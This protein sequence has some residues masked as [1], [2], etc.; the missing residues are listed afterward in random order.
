MHVLVISRS[1]MG[2]QKM[3]R[4]SSSIQIVCVGEKSGRVRPTFFRM[5]KR[6]RSPSPQDVEHPLHTE[7]IKAIS[8]PAK[9]G[10][11]WTTEKKQNAPG[12]SDGPS[13]GDELLE[14]LSSLH[15]F[16]SDATG[17]LMPD[18]LMEMID[19]LAKGSLK[20]V[21][22]SRIQWA[23]NQTRD[24]LR[25]LGFDE[26]FARTRCAQIVTE[27]ARPMQWPWRSK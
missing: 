12:L 22:E 23:Q 2:A 25:P 5:Q 10:S 6:S 4:V 3:A 18:A 15:R 9:D 14:V 16:G 26:K 24:V 8:L 17:S 7:V 19:S 21:G 20:Q 27:R 13:N 1:D 11:N